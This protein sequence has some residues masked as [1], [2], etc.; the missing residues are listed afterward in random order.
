MNIADEMNKVAEMT[1]NNNKYSPVYFEI[2]IKDKTVL[3]IGMEV[4][5]ISTLTNIANNCSE[6]GRED[7]VKFCTSEPE[8]FIGYIP[9]MRLKSNGVE[10]VRRAIMKSLTD[11]WEDGYI[12][13]YVTNKRSIKRPV[14]D[15]ETTIE[16]VKYFVNAK[17]VI[18]KDNLDNINKMVGRE[19][20]DNLE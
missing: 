11:K 6:I 18:N 2:L 10:T 1:E 9:N 15:W 16:I 4:G 3:T 19:I 14:S 20:I 17:G 12:T 7:I 5:L 13:V 8:K